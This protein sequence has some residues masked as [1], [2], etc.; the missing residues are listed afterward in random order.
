MKKVSINVFFEDIGHYTKV[1]S[2]IIFIENPILHSKK[3]SF[4][5]LSL[6]GMF[7]LLKKP[8]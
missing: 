7:L 3:F 4:T 1:F 5:F 6:C 8:P 2:V